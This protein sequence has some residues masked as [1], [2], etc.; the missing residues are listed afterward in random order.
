MSEGSGDQ[1]DLR[2]PKS[3]NNTLLSI[4]GKGAPSVRVIFWGIVSALGIAFFITGYTP[5]EHL[6]PEEVDKQIVADR[7]IRASFGFQTEDVRA[8]LEARRQAKDKV[9]PHYRI[10]KDIVNAKMAVLEKRINAILRVISEFENV[11]ESGGE[12]ITTEGIRDRLKVYLSEDGSWVDSLPGEVISVLFSGL[13]TGA[14]IEG[15]YKIEKSDKRG[16]AD[17]ITEVASKSL[18]Y[19]LLRGIKS[20]DDRNL[21]AGKVVIIREN[22]IDILKPREELQLVDIPD[23]DTAL[24]IELTR[25]V[26]QVCEKVTANRSTKINCGEIDDVVI[27]LIN[28]LIVATLQYDPITTDLV[29]ERASEEVPPIMKEIA[30]GEIIQERGKRWTLESRSDAKT[31]L[32]LLKQS[33][34]SA[35]RWIFSYISNLIIVGVALLGFYRA[36][37]LWEHKGEP[38]FETVWNLGILL[39]FVTSALARGMQYFDPSGFSVPVAIVGILFAILVQVRLSAFLS[40]IACVLVSIVFKYDWRLLVFYV[41]MTFGSVFMVHRVRKRGDITSACLSGAFF[42]LLLLLAITFATESLSAEN[43][44]RRLFLLGINVGLCILAVPGLLPF[45]ERWFDIVTDFQLL[46][47]SDLNNKLLKRLAVEA[48]AT[49]SHSLMLGQLAEVAADAIGA[50]GLLARVCAYYHDIGKITRAE[51]FCENQNGIN[52]HDALTPRNSAR[53]IISHVQ[54]G[55]KL[56][57]EFKLPK[58]IIDAIAQHHGTFKV[59]YF[60]YRALEQ[61]KYDDVL[62]EDYRYPGPKPQRPEYA[63]L[64]ICDACESAV[65]SLKNPNPERIRQM[66]DRIVTERANDGQFDEC[67]LTLK[68]LNII[69]DVVAKNLHSLLHT[70][71]P[72]PSEEENKKESN[73]ESQLNSKNGGSRKS[74]VISSER[75]NAGGGG[76]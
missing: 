19:I 76:K 45:L 72:Y 36:I 70:R 46:E 55:V 63:I 65:R 41:A 68:Q 24:T 73:G 75:E 49:Y 40:F 74:I 37:Q 16:D 30:A 31:Y 61:R 54:D 43:T 59:T 39:L 20:S 1:R 23:L 9:P 7:E 13:L 34:G 10:N 38:N 69:V 11:V 15:E 44:I 12:T 29:R 8:T 60:Y 17:T 3:R 62:E 48:P 66:V 51:Y 52:I 57:Q 64:M 53:V 5:T 6:T 18:E 27:P 35:V 25:V 22:P 21:T 47:Y 56:A 32:S 33:Q 71:V 67:D 50:N 26:Q 4:G 2:F 58:P 28:D 14:I 42:G